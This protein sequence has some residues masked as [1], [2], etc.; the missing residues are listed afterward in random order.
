M[1]DEKKPEALWIAQLNEASRGM[2]RVLAAR[3]LGKLA[4][5]TARPALVSAMAKDAFWA[6]RG[7]SGRALAAL[8]GVASR[9]ALVARL[10]SENHPKARRV[11]VRALGAFRHDAEAANAVSRLL[12]Q[13]D[14]SYLVESEAATALGKIRAPGAFEAL[15]SVIDRPAH[16][17]LIAVGVLHGLYELRDERG[18]AIAAERARY[19][20]PANARAAAIACLGSLAAEHAP[21]RRLAR[22]RLSEL[23]VDDVDFRARSAAVSALGTLGDPDA[24]GVLDRVAHS[25]VDGRVR[26]SAKEV[27]RDLA[28]G[29]AQA[30]QLLALRDRAEELEKAR[31]ELR[32]R[33]SQLEAQMKAIAPGKPS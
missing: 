11:L 19:G 29:R 14:A 17:D 10:P 16:R 8:R 4:A 20:A 25:D 26:R 22:E 7:E 3:A 18:V 31:D 12:T 28:A 23:A 24:A 21:H 5:P 13:G 27:A 30:D 6:V 15:L 32:D 1:V 9:E 2:D 33:I